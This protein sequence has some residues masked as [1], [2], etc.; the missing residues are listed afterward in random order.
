DWIDIEDAEEPEDAEEIV[1]R[2]R[3]MR[4]ATLSIQ[5]FA[6]VD[7]AATGASAP[8]A[9]L[10]SVVAAANLPTRRAALN[11]AGVG[12]GSL[13]PVQSIDGVLGS[14]VFEPRATLEV[15]L[16]LTG[17]VTEL[18]TYVESVDL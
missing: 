17:E 1:H 18:G 16:F 8:A 2:S 6:G 14:S 11:A 9:L 7:G 4:E 15:R 3:G 12:I 5:C 10:H 13:G